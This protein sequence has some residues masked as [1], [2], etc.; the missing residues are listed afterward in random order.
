MK[1]TLDQFWDKSSS[2]RGKLISEALEQDR[3]NEYIAR[4]VKTVPIRVTAST[5]TMLELLAAVDESPTWMVALKTI[6]M[7]CHN[8]ER[9]DNY[10]LSKLV[11]SDSYDI[12]RKDKKHKENEVIDESIY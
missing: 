11:V 7:A 8:N 5:K 4:N 10:L 3:D 9:I 6:L 1:I 2:E 12:H